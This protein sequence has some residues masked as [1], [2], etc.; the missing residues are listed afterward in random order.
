MQPKVSILLP[1]YNAAKYLRFAIDSIVS[2]TY[3][4]L[5]IILINDGSTDNTGKIIDEFASRDSRI[6]V[7]NNPVNLGL[8]KTLNKGITYI[9]G[10]YTARMD[11]DD[12]SQVDRIEKLV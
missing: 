4:N 9:T 5:E 6:V 3:R 7:V 12:I 8:I 10:Y 2:Q 11:A 1:C